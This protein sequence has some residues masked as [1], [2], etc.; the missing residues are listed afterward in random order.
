MKIKRKPEVSIIIL[1]WNER[2]AL[3]KNLALIFNQKYQ[4]FEVIV[5]DSGSTDGTLELLKKYPA[6]VIHYKGPVGNR[7][8]YARALNLG[9]QE[10]KGEFLVRLSAHTL[11]Y[12]RNWL[13][14]LLGP[15]FDPLVAGTYSRQIHSPKSGLYHKLLWFIGFSRFHWFFEKFAC[16]TLFWASSCGIRK[17]VWQTIPFDEKIKQT[18]DP[19]WA[20]AV[21]KR[22]YKTV[23]APRSMVRHSHY[24]SIGELIK[25]RKFWQALWINTKTYLDGV[26]FCFSKR[27]L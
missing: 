18:E 22:G 12:N 7:F 21:A 8:N 5:V 20:L 9:A 25:K 17:K 4:D 19:V 6:R 14:E 11:P 27:F 26:G 2:K 10:A 3:E 1:S 24:E 23:Y 13:G 16:Y 15:F